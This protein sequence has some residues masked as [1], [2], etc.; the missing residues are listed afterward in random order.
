MLKSKKLVEITGHILFVIIFIFFSTLE[1]K[2]LEKYNKGENIADYFSGILLL[3][4]S[5]YTDSH[6]FFKK[7]D[8]LEESH[9]N[10]SR[11]YI[12]S[13][14]NSGN[15]N[16]AFNFAKKL[17]KAQKSNYESDLVLG[18][19]YLKKSKYDLAKKYFIEA[20]KNNSISILN[21]YILD[22]LYIWSDLEGSTLE[23][24]KLKLNQLDNRFDNL[25]KIQNV[26]LHCYFESKDTDFLFN[27]LISNDKTDFSR[28]Y[29]FYA[30]H[31]DNKGKKI[32][33]RKIT[34]AALKKY[35]RNLI[36]NQYK[37]NLD[38]K[39]NFSDF[40]CGNKVEIVAELLYIAANALSSQ[41]YFQTSNF[42]LN[43]SKY[44][45]KNFYSFDTLLAENFYQIEN[46]ESAKKT[47]Q[48][49]SKNGNAFEWHSNKQISRILIK[50]NRKEDAIKL[51]TNSFNNLPSKGIYEMYD[52]AEFL[53]NNEQY[54]DS[55]N[56]YT[57]ILEKID[58][59]HPLFPEVT[60]SRGV[61]YERNGQW[62]KAEKDLLA[63][64]E[65]SPNQAYVINYLA[66]TWIEQ[67]IKI[68]KSLKML[69]KANKIKSN[70]PYIIDSL[71]WALY[72]LKRYKESK[73]YLQL[74]VKLMPADPIVNDHYGDVLWQNGNEI[75]ARYYWNYVLNLEKAEK[76]LK[77]KIEQKLIK[78]L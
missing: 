72:K 54:G 10:Y 16:E 53:K 35:P 62:D 19:N 64:L 49:L 2:N 29:Y 23:Q 3:S 41:L 17:N 38:L 40:N 31:L 78:G 18:L 77:A 4:Q 75:Q 44:L 48:K 61:A 73:D 21:N 11:K 69:E 14:I 67:G 25:K 46:L 55:I 12:Y 51:Y 43:F 60:D 22:T 52:Y 37:I 74:A 47:Y 66:Y 5:K 24:A 32:E 59:T 57:K 28:Y 33:A 15:F 7:L 71:G 1:A 6:S 68:E 30:R 58:T 50:E 56:Y 20:K 65:V 26:F 8:G 9:P 34:K 45:N 76:D 39:N 70:D 42:Y 27:K 63:S 13:L 36:L